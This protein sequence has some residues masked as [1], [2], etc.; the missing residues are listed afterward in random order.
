MAQMSCAMDVANMRYAII[1]GSN[2]TLETEYINHA[3][4]PLASAM[5]I[6]RGTAFNVPFETVKSSGGAAVGSGFRFCAEAFAAKVRAEDFAEMDVAEQY[7]LDNAAVLGALAKS[8][9][10][11]QIERVV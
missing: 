7:S 1:N 11:G 5:R 4:V 8:A 10:S 9:K 2:G 3:G 6:R